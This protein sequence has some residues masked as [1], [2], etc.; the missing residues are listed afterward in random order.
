LDLLLTASASV[1]TASATNGNA[2]IAIAQTNTARGMHTSRSNADI[3]VCMR[4]KRFTIG[5]TR[6]NSHK[7]YNSKNDSQHGATPN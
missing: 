3:G 1:P 4:F 2:H 6:S 7:A 5:T